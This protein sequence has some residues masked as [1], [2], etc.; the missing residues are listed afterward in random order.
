M[1]ANI[2]RNPGITVSELAELLFMDQTTVTRNLQ[3]LEK[4]G[5]I[6]METERET[7]GSKKFEF[8]I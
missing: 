4:S 5:Y 8:R 6:N 1:L 7:I 3:V 2:A